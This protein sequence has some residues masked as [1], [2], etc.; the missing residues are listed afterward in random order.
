[1]KKKI[2][3][4]IISILLVLGSILNVSSVKADS[5]FDFSYDSSSSSDYDSGSY[6]SGRGSSSNDG[7][8][9]MIATGL[10]IIY[11][12]IIVL[13]VLVIVYKIV[14]TRKA[15][16][17]KDVEIYNELKKYN[18]DFEELTKE[19]SNDYIKIQEA[20]SNFDY[21][22]L[23]EYLTDELYNTY[24]TELETLKSKG[25][26]NIM[27]H[28]DVEEIHLYECKEEN[29]YLS[30]AALIDVTQ[31]DYIVN[32]NGKVVRGHKS[33]VHEVI[34]CLTFVKPLNIG[35]DICPNCGAKLDNNSDKCPNCRSEIIRPKN[36]FVLSKKT[37][38]NQRS[39]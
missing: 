26:Q 15:L 17:D 9:S 35:S 33:D 5:G 29:G 32:T 10:Q 4:I 18:I 25:E 6:G 38:E 19:F 13:G 31:C 24:V 21:D 14:G 1:M 2:N 3:I 23:K 27:S 11:T 22:T 7:A 28:I 37:I 34:Y 20:W 12:T 8:S 16:R 30:V 36:K 39:L